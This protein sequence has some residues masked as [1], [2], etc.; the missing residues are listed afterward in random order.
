MK[1]RYAEALTPREREVLELLSTGCTNEEI[2]RHLGISLDGVKYHVSGIFRRLRVT[3]RREAASLHLGT[4]G[5]VLTHRE[6]EVIELLSTGLTNEEI[7]RRLGISLEGVKYHVSGILRRL[8][9]E[10]RREAASLHLRVAGIGRLA[11]LAP[12]VFLRKLPFGWLGKAAASA[13]LTTTAAGIALLVWGVVSTPTATVTTTGCSV[14]Q[15]AGG[16]LLCTPGAA[17]AAGADAVTQILAGT[18]FTCALKGGGVW[19]WGGNSHGQLGNNSTTDIDVPVPAA[20]LASGVSALSPGPC[21]VK[22]DGLWCWGWNDAAGLGNNRTSES[23]VP[24]LVSGLASGAGAIGEAPTWFELNGAINKDWVNGRCALKDGGVLCWG[25]G[26]IG[27]TE[28]L[29]PVPGLESGVSAIS[30]NCALKDGGVS[31]WEIPNNGTRFAQPV[32]VAGLERG[33]SAISGNCALKNGAVWCGAGSFAGGFP[34]ASAPLTGLASGVSAIS[35]FGQL[36]GIK[37]PF[38]GGCAIKGGGLWCWSADSYVSYTAP[39]AMP[40]LESGVSAISGTC[41][42]KEGGV[43]CWGHNNSGQLGNISSP[44]DSPVPV[45]VQFPQV[46]TDDIAPTPDAKPLPTQTSTDSGGH[47]TAYVLGGTTAAAVTAIV[48]AGA[49]AVRRR[50]IT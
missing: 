23:H 8:D 41:A 35:G 16:A 50:R 10:S 47:R 1:S 33:V 21:A 42:L 30:G 18:D 45:A 48:V 27:T 22:D 24:V 14:E 2:A 31:C 20:G 5:G 34:L 15:T 49:W 19:C 9:V 40:G 37:S 44:T 25:G 26:L 46:S 6:Q 43:W 32:A 38:A 7:A 13:A 39:V 12:F 11:A 29:G 3:S 28:S 36:G 17:Q 4:E